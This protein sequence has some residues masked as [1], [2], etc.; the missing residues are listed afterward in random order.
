MIITSYSEQ[1]VDIG[2][3]KTIHVYT[4]NYYDN[5]LNAIRFNDDDGR[6]YGVTNNTEI[7]VAKYEVDF[8][9]G[10]YQIST[11]SMNL[12]FNYIANSIALS[13][14]GMISGFNSI[15]FV[16]NLSLQLSYFIVGF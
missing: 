15:A 13:D 10:G 8:L 7:T 1:L 4:S 11:G 12:E 16:S 6:I 5:F 3:I 14:I 2:D 9:F